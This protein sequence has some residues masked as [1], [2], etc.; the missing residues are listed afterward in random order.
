MRSA[1]ILLA[2]AGCDTTSTVETTTGS[3]VP[4]PG[5]G[6]IQDVYQQEL[7]PAFDALCPR[8]PHPTPSR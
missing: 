8:P 1:L 4:D 2:V 6:L 5:A 7:E 3:N